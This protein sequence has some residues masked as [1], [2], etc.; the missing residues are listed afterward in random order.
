M[1]V[2]IEKLVYGGDGLGHADGH[3]VFV[4]GVLPGE[5]VRVRPLERKKKFVRARLEELLETSAQRA[6]PPCPHFGVCGGCHYQH[7]PYELQLAYKTDILRETLRRLGRICW[8]ADIIAHASPPFGYRNRAQWKIRAAGEGTGI[9]YFQAGTSALCAVEQCPILAPLLEATLGGLRR[10]GAAGE[11]PPVL[12]EV[13]AFCDAAGQRML[14]SA[15]L[16]EFRTAPAEYA[17][18]LRAEFPAIESLLLY[19]SSR[20]RF[21]LF[22][23]GYLTYEVSGQRYQVGHLSF[24]QVNRFLIEPMVEAVCGTQEGELALDLFAGAGL[25]AA[26]LARRFR[27]V[28]AVESNAA[29]ARDLAKNLAAATADVQ[30]V[31]SEVEEFLIKF[32]E[33]P[34]LV[35]LDPPRA[36]V[37]ARSLERIVALRPESIVYLS[38]D[39]AT[40]ARD[41]HVLADT[42]WTISELHLFDVFPQTFHIES[43]VRLAP[44]G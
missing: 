5:V 38:C 32:S 7:I 11:L 28:V 29:A 33:R 4:P 2:R 1:Q 6:A 14:L 34:S 43:L 23:P 27:R 31:T 44:S 13:E 26:P 40:L 16:T 10:M 30:V 35:V 9:G 21:E 18:L 37:S 19:E 17:D 42:G 8:D 12:R 41:L 15:S 22:G 39:P 3:T 36:G 20:D 25:F 24:F